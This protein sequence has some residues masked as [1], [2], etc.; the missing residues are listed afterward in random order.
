MIQTALCD[1]PL[2]RV[3]IAVSMNSPINMHFPEALF[4]GA[5]GKTLKRISCSAHGKSCPACFMRFNCPF[6]TLFQP[7]LPDRDIPAE[8]S[9][10]PKP[11]SLRIQ[12]HSN[13]KHLIIE[14]SLFGSTNRFFP[15][16][17]E[18]LKQMSRT[19]I[20]NNRIQFRIDAVLDHYSR[21]PL[22]ENILPEKNPLTCQAPEFSDC[23]NETL[24][25]DLLSPLRLKDLGKVCPKPQFRHLVK[26]SIKRL[27]LLNYCYGN[28][29]Q[30]QLPDWRSL[31]PDIKVLERKTEWIQRKRLSS[32][33]D[34]SIGYSGVIG[35]IVFQGN[36]KPF[37]PLLQTAGTI[38]IG[39]GTTFGSG[40]M[41]IT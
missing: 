8:Y 28:S 20:G 31:M 4:R 14:L 26:A 10:I 21:Q 15:V 11:Y 34:K 2:S 7:A 23:S 39:K 3:E 33:Q 19:G 24:T 41:Q 35:R 5:L 29:T 30:F 27:Q 22:V 36:V 12:N 9:T 40:R 18:A 38:G 17:M 1:I 37:I 25:V 6:T 32:I 16:I 13:G